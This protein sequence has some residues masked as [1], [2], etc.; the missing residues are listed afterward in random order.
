M[1]AY[2]EH[3]SPSESFPEP[4]A[5]LAA[6]VV[7]AETEERAGELASSMGLAWVRMRTGKPGPLPSPEEALSYPYSTAE[8]RLLESYRSM[9]VVGD[10]ESVREHLTGMAESTG[11]DEVMVTTMVYDHGARLRSYELLAEAFG[12]E[13][14]R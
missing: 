1:L 6:S 2:R 11:A 13:G 9:Q 12:L 4:H 14:G 5:I 8:R 10:P 7:C 3:F